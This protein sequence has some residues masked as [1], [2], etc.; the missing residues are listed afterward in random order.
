MMTFPTAHSEDAHE[1]VLNLLKDGNFT[2]QEI[3]DRTGVS[4]R[5]IQRWASKAKLTEPRSSSMSAEDPTSSFRQEFDKSFF[6][7]QRVKEIIK[8]WLVDE[9]KWWAHDEEMRKRCGITNVADWKK[10]ARE[11]KEFVVYQVMLPNKKIAWAKDPEYK[12]ELQRMALS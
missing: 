10:Y 12:E 4:K 5:T 9:K 11:N 3:A 8:K 7:P 6:I 1:E 2:H